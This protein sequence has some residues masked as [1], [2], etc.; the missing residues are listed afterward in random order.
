MMGSRV[1][2][3]RGV[4]ARRAPM[5][6]PSPGRPLTMANGPRS[7][8]GDEAASV[9]CQ[10]QASQRRGREE[11]LSDG[12]LLVLSLL[13]LLLLVSFI[14]FNWPDRRPQRH[15]CGD[16]VDHLWLFLMSQIV[17]LK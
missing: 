15:V 13:L 10:S 14:V 8:G 11:P 6:G 17:P 1:A 9:G 16:G 3:E 2:S 7:E 12:G 5:P 4:G